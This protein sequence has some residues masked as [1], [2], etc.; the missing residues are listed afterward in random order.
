MS[1]RRKVSPV[2]ISLFI[3]IALAAALLFASG[4]Y[5]DFLRSEERRV[6]QDC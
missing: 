2:R 5:T 3:L 4:L 6:G 1:D